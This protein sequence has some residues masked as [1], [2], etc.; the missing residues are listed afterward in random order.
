M[1]ARSKASLPFLSDYAENAVLQKKFNIE[2]IS[3]LIQYL[4]RVAPHYQD[5][6]LTILDL[7]CGDGGATYYLLQEC[8][9]HGI[10]V[11]RMVGID[12]SSSQIEHAQRY[13]LYD[14]ATSLQFICED[15]TKITYENEF[16][17]V[18][19]L[20]GLHWINDLPLI[21]N[22][23]HSALKDDGVTMYFVPL[24][25][26]DFFKLRQ[27]TMHQE[28][29]RKIFTDIESGI[30]VIS[31]FQDKHD[32]YW[33]AFSQLFQETNSKQN[34]DHKP[35]KVYGDQPVDFS[36]Q[37]WF[38]FLSSWMPEI[39]FLKNRFPGEEGIELS[40]QYLTDLTSQIRLSEKD[41]QS[42]EDVSRFNH[43]IRFLEKFFWF[44][45]QKKSNS[46]SLDRDVRVSKP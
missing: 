26:I 39:R 41:E 38:K 6:G 18:I 10:K 1:E 30:F 45:G 24:E 32:P 34:S 20:F 46:I 27:S 12:S 8:L 4:L 43:S 7:C 5:E 31:P 2:I 13:T 29:W 21:A 28:K 15:I 22:K 35:G 33:E 42:V 19:S 14:R 44:H 36:M 23:I 9:K 40:A 37:E 11:K 25:K 3:D 17:V 16:D